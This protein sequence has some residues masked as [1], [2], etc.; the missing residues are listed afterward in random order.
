MKKFFPQFESDFRKLLDAC[1]GRNIAVVG[2]LRPDGDCISSEFALADLLEKSGAEKVVCLNEHPI[3]HLYVNFAYSRELLSAEAFD[4]KSFEIVTVDCADY[5]RT[6]K[7]LCERF[8]NP[9]AAIDHHATNSGAARINIIDPSAA[10]TAELI[11]GLA[12]DAGLEISKHNADRLLMGIVMDTRSFTTSSTRGLTYEIAAMLS[13]RGADSAF[14]AQQLYQRERP[15]KLALLAIYLKSLRSHFGGNLR[16]GTLTLA[17]YAES[18]AEK[19]DSDGLVDYARSI[20]G[21]EIGALLEELKIGVKGSLRSKDP[22]MR[23]SDIAKMFGGGGHFAAAGFTAKGET[24]DSFMPKFL[25]AVE[26]S[27]LKYHK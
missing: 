24:L 4:D 12:C 18:G 23:V 26:S 8:P 25:E 20:D 1:A 17:D 21:A 13:E 10:A 3:P 19:A 14:V 16:L 15:E 9:L 27:I 22:A 6:N 5:S 2:H 7:A 11:A